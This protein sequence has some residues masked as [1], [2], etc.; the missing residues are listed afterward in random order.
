MD[1]ADTENHET[2]AKALFSIAAERWHSSI[3][4]YELT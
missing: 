3:V 2:L 1:I 4:N